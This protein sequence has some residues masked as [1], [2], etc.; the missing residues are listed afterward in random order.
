MFILNKWFE[1]K[2][3]RNFNTK[4]TSSG[5]DLD[6]GP[7]DFGSDSEISMILE[8]MMVSHSLCSIKN[9]SDLRVCRFYLNCVC[10][11]WLKYGFYIHFSRLFKL[12]CF[13]CRLAI[14]SIT[15]SKLARIKL[16]HWGSFLL[17]INSFSI[18]WTVKS[19]FKGN[20]K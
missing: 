5:L 16:V 2:T 13:F 15:S 8:A 7:S 20:E 9:Y 4:M 6:F 14:Y 17:R 12:K 18:S 11:I 1:N 3:C 10:F 19:Y